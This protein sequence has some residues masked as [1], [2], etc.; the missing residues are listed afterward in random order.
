MKSLWPLWNLPSWI[1]ALD[2]RGCVWHSYNRYTAV[3]ARVLRRALKEDKRIAAE[4]RGESE[5]RF[6]KWTVSKIYVF[7][8]RLRRTGD[9]VLTTHSHFGQNGKMG[10][11]QRVNVASTKSTEA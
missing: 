1:E 7:P 6:A 8:G 5:L 10:E 9:R 2:S 11:P 3:A 4:R